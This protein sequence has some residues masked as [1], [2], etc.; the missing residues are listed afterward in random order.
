MAAQ[1]SH[2]QQETLFHDILPNLQDACESLDVLH[3][4][5]V[6][7]EEDISPRGLAVL[8]GQACIHLRDARDT[9]T[10]LR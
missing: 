3:S 6:Y 1:F 9:L 2:A 8:L 5:L 7:G 4:L 10:A